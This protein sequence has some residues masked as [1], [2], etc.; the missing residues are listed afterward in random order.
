MFEQNLELTIKCR[1]GE[2][3]IG[4]D[5]ELCEPV[6]DTHLDEFL[7]RFEGNEEFEVLRKRSLE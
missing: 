6:C 5:Y 2:P 4:I 7:K 1:C 3:A